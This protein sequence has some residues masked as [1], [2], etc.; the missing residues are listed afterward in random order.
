[1]DF[2][3]HDK[4][5]EEYKNEMLKQYKRSRNYISPT[6]QSPQ[7]DTTKRQQEQTHKDVD[8]QSVKADFQQQ[9]TQD[10]QFT[11]HQPVVLTSV[12]PHCEHD[13]NSQAIAPEKKQ[14][15]AKEEEKLLEN[16]QAN[17]SSEVKVSPSTLGKSVAVMA[18]D[19][20]ALIPLAARQ[21]N[22]MD[23][24]VQSAAVNSTPVL[25]E[26]HENLQQ[27]RTHIKSM[28]MEEEPGRGSNFELSAEEGIGSLNNSSRDIMDQM[29]PRETPQ[30]TPRQ[31][32]TPQN[33]ETS[34]QEGPQMPQQDA[35]PS[36]DNRAAQAPETLQPEEPID[37]TMQNYYNRNISRGFLRLQ[38]TSG[39]GAVPIEGVEG[40]ISKTVQDREYIIG[41]LLTDSS[42]VSKMIA[43]PAPNRSLSE[44]PRSESMQELPYATYDLSVNAN[45]FVPVLI[46]DIPIFDGIVSIQPIGLHPLLGS[47]QTVPPETIQESEPNL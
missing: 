29:P 30:Q 6:S 8:V 25:N 27:L 3:N 11:E 10:L 12:W 9:N 23:E 1:M 37:D 17:Q 26:S 40:I 13:E 20:D 47:E 38:V 2:Q 28:E 24:S 36:E 41:R 15:N 5:M 18:M 4:R 21:E 43:L 7:R 19:T 32:Q 44:Q 22:G 45:N 39:Q 14:E 42:G 46:K 31:Q 34:R 16:H 35:M 33:S